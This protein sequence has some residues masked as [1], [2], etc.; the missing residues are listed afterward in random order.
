MSYT[1]YIDLTYLRDTKSMQQVDRG[2][3]VIEEEQKKKSKM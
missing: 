1:D 2:Q 3:L